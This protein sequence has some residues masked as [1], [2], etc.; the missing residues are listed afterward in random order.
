MSA[1]TAPAT[2]APQFTPTSAIGIRTPGVHHVALRVTDLSRARVFYIDRLGFP[3]LLETPDLLLFAAGGTAF[4]IRGPAA[5]TDPSDSFSPFR[6]GLDHVALACTDE[7]ELRRVAAALAAGGVENTGVKRDET[8]QKN[9]VAFRD[10]DGIKWE[11][12]MADGTSAQRRAELR[13]AADAY[14]SGLASKDLSRIP[15]APDVR[16]RAPL[17]PGGAEVPQVGSAALAFLEQVLPAIG[18]VRVIDYYINDDLTGISAV[19]HIDLVSPPVT[20]RVSDRFMVDAAGRIVEQEN[21]YDPRALTGT[22]RAG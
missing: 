7:D 8:L 11:L 18:D 6:V 22:D 21:H 15:Y 20:L 3:L 4:A 14:F 2:I 1:M 9:Y 16:L 12:Y 17:A 10:P 13:A 5:D 19:A